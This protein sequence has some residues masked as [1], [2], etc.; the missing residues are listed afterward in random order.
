MSLITQ[1][2]QKKTISRNKVVKKQK[3]FDNLKKF[4]CKYLL[5]HLLQHIIFQ[6]LYIFC[7]LGTIWISGIF[8]KDLQVFIQGNFI[9]GT[10]L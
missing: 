8:C 5:I 1:Y 7:M 3:H 10:K 2:Y 9:T 4:V 6:A